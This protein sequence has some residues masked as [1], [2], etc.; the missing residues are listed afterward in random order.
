MT[1]Q[2]IASVV[3][4]SLLALLLPPA[5]AT[6][7]LFVTP[8]SAGYGLT[9]PEYAFDP[10]HSYFNPDGSGGNALDFTSGD[11]VCTSFPPIDAPSGTCTSP[12]VVPTYDFAYIWLQY[13]NEPVGA[14]FNGIQIVIQE[15]GA[16][17]A[18][19]NV[20]YY[21][22]NNLE[23]PPPT[24]HKRWDGTATPP[25]YPEWRENPQVLIA[26]TAGGI[27]NLAFD[28]PPEENWD[29][30]D[31]QATGGSWATGVALLG[32]VQGELGKTYTIDITN[33]NYV[34]PPNPTV[35]GG[36]FYFGGGGPLP[37]P[38]DLN[39][40][41]VID[42]GDINPFVMYLTD[43]GA[44]LA[45]YPACNPLN[46]DINGDGVYGQGSFGDINP[47]VDLLTTGDPPPCPQ[48]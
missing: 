14:R 43:F 21:L 3:C 36:A 26:I 12:V 39:C 17:P 46:G 9:H 4:V 24:N 2:R 25:A 29:M 13:Q 19:I 41:G 10:T 22:Q 18:A 48:E 30:Y 20:C 6:V 7:R 8:A 32:A 33:I 16:E 40:D 15:C 23:G 31:V 47:F 44:W 45:N 5:R 27:P 28:P 38:G 35:A 37:C 34:T 11:F 42:F 1:T